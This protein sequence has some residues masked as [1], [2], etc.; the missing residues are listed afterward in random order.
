MENK[1]LVKKLNKID[2]N[3]VAT[4]N[5]Q[6]KL[7]SDF[8]F[9]LLIGDLNKFKVDVCCLQETHT[10]DFKKVY[11]DNEGKKVLGKIICF[12][13]QNVNKNKRYGQGFFITEKWIR[14]INKFGRINDRLSF[15][16]F[17]INNVKLLILNV[18]A[19]TSIITQTNKQETIIFYND[20][21]KYI[22][23]F[24]NQNDILIIGGDFN[25]KIG[26]KENS[27]NDFM[28]NFGRNTN[29]NE[30]GNFLA[31]T[32]L[33]NKLFIS[34]T[35]FKHSAR[36]ISTW[37]G[38]GK[39]NNNNKHIIKNNETHKL[40]FNQ[41]DYILINKRDKLLL[42]DSRSYEG[43]NYKSDHKLV[44]T[45]LNLNDYF[46]NFKYKYK[47]IKIKH[48]NLDLLVNDEKTKK[49][50][51][52]KLE[53]NIELLQVKNNIT[54]EYNDLL[55][56]IKKS[57]DDTLPI[58]KD[59]INNILYYDDDVLNEL[60]D[61]RNKLFKK[62]LDNKK[63]NIFNNEEMKY[64]KKNRNILLLKIRKRLKTLYNNKL[65]DLSKELEKNKSNNNIYYFTKY[66]NKG[67]GYNDFKLI[68][69][70]KCEISN[71]KD[72]IENI[73]K[74]YI[75]F[76]NQDNINPVNLWEGNAKSLINRIS[77]IEVEIASKMLNNGR[78]CGK[79][80]I[81]G[82]YIKYG[83]IKLYDKIA[84]T[85]NKIFENHINI[86]SILEGILIPLN[87]PNKSYTANNT[88]PITLLN[89]TRKIL[90]NILLNRIYSKLDNNISINQSGFRYKR[91]TTDIVWAY[92]WL[93]AISKKFN[94]EINIIG[95]DLSKAF[96]C[97]NRNI[98]LNNIKE[99]IDDDEYRILKYLLSETT[100]STRINNEYGEK[101]NTSIGTPQGDALSPILFNYYL[102]LALKEFMDKENIQFNDDELQF[103]ISFADD[104]DLINLIKKDENFDKN[105]Q[106]KLKKLA[107]VLMKYNLKMNIEKTEF[108]TIN[109]DNSKLICNRKLG[110]KISDTIDI[111]NRKLLA[112]VAFNKLNN[113]WK[114]KNLIKLD[115]KLKLYR[116]YVKSIL[117]YNIS[118]LT[119]TKS[120]LNKLDSFHRKQ[121]RMLC[122]IY[123]P[124]TIR[125]EKLYN[126]TDE[127]PISLEI[128]KYRWN[129]FGRI[130]NL[131]DN[132]A[133]NKI[134][135]KYFTLN[136]PSDLRSVRTTLPNL[137]NSDLICI[138]QY[139]KKDFIE[140]FTNYKDM[141]FQLRNINDFN[142]I[143]NMVKN[144]KKV[145]N[146]LK[147][148][149]LDSA[150]LDYFYI[151]YSP[152]Y[153]KRKYIEVVADDFYSNTDRRKNEV[154]KN[155][156][157]VIIEKEKIKKYEDYN[158]IHK[159]INNLKRNFNMINI[160]D[161]REI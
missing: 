8:D 59:L 61:K 125:N 151:C 15:I 149:I 9:K 150:I 68:D 141:K 145:W 67:Y 131:N 62:F 48:Y 72:L 4:W 25:A 19:P 60:V 90:S 1:N 88:R 152:E 133:A 57:I 100:L 101:F 96:D 36:H 140:K 29:R 121:L 126:I 114:R 56:C 159:L 130:L 55:D 71:N 16:E 2:Y 124:K 144:S 86:E 70:N 39:I 106:D 54:E 158:N 122:N 7:N 147:D 117:I 34:N 80:N 143:K 154:R 134:M 78:A 69:D 35:N 63:K 93:M 142:Y 77:S 95:I 11:K 97:I 148:I 120:D 118:C 81:Y 32:C 75:Q 85:L 73:N 137:L 127:I 23:E 43:T 119:L 153:K 99:I 33:N 24:K 94:I 65:I 28:G 160:Y 104:T 128:I 52:K 30:N 116:I 27:Y 76:Y 31:E 136:R 112:K 42:K 89:M 139:F 157:K 123:Y 49:E 105:C 38:H 51:H 47:N 83:N 115:T 110:N 10:E 111:E 155:I 41:I 17:K 44:I 132:I 107:E 3:R 156:V 12:E 58:K 5:I 98:L 21:N 84:E 64:Y 14:Y 74:F 20:L 103:I 161:R 45:T 146:N 6:G 113:I 135:M 26:R 22:N 40:Y 108:I 37:R 18:Y 50:Y 53:E 13:G 87:K 138:N 91:S 66:L 109:K 129:F 92:R 79:D 102:N 46:D 82:E